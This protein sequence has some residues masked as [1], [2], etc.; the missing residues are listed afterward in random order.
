MIIE[1]ASKKLLDVLAEYIY[2]QV[3]LIPDLLQRDHH[4]LLC[5]GHQHEVEAPLLLVHLH[6]RQAR[7]VH[8]N[9][10][11]GHD[12]AQQLRRGPHFHPQRVPLGHEGRDLAGA[13]DVALHDVAAHPRYRLQ[14]ALEVDGGPK[15]DLT[16]GGPAEGLRREA[17][18]E[19]GG[20]G[21]EVGHGEAGA[22]DGDA[23]TELDAFEDGARGDA[24]L[25]AAVIVPGGAEAL[26]VAHLLHDAGEEARE[27]A[28]SRGPALEGL[29]AKGS[30]KE[31]GFEKDGR[32][33]RFKRERVGDGEVAIASARRGRKKK[34][35]FEPGEGKMEADGG[36]RR[37]H[38]SVRR[39]EGSKKQGGENW[40][41]R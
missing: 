26:D 35:G 27:G 6:H 3:H 23:V 18:G 37:R 14:G 31:E 28:R 24:H 38:C 20:A 40:G 1:S 2:L 15:A 36:R 41:R 19:G 4:L 10:P 9:E 8:R 16:E 33:R 32:R 30:G 11:L 22:V 13:V 7:P 17:D 12:V 39:F 34:R 21:V 25:D 5:V 29:G